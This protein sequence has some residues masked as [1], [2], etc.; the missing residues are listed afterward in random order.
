M[1]SY[2]K[3]ALKHI[4]SSENRAKFKKLKRRF[5]SFMKSA[6]KNKITLQDFEKTLKN[7]IG[8]KKGDKVFVTSSFGNLNTTF[9]PKEL[10]QL[11]MDIV[12]EEGT[13]MMP[14]YPPINSDEWA[15]GDKV[16]DMAETKSGMGII[17]N[18]F[19]KMPKVLK[20]VH[21]TKAVCVWGKDAEILI[22]NHEVST[23]PFYWDSPYGKFLKD[24]C[25]TLGLGVRNNPIFHTIE[26]IVSD[27][28]TKYYL[29]QK[30]KLKLITDKKEIMDIETYIHNSKILSKCISSGEYIEKLNCKSYNKTNIGISYIYL[31]N[32][33]EVYEKV[34][35]L[36]KKGENKLRFK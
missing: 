17:T 4:I 36:V 18:V 20:S 14:Y 22:K 3:I 25:F 5:M 6:D 8:L 31:I 12:T 21:P 19:S 26:D 28:V 16:F 34:Q 9:S 13:I 29:P 23:T 30:Y 7:D 11:L 15:K 32:N 27:P 35:D 2:I 24:G 33:S 10:V 1:I